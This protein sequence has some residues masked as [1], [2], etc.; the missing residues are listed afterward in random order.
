MEKR[1]RVR[2]KK[3]SQRWTFDRTQTVERKRSKNF[4]TDNF[5]TGTHARTHAHAHA[6]AHPH[7]HPHMSLCQTQIQTAG[8]L[9]L[10]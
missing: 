7:P 1:F 5:P 2:R 6:H 4:L 3:L 9:S 10:P 8:S